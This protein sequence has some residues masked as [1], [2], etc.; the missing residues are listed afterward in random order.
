[1]NYKD[2]MEKCEK[3]IEEHLE[4]PPSATE[5]AEFSGY[6][7]YH[8][9]HLFRAHFGVPV[10]EYAPSKAKIAICGN[11]LAS[12]EQVAMMIG[13]TLKV[14]LD[15]KYLDATDA[16]AIE[17]CHYYQTS[18]PLASVKSKGGWKNF[19]ESNPERVKK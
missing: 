4:Y 8:F 11:G 18:N 16:V 6:S 3:Y 19:I 15:P 13:K 2:V 7:L 17:M 14:D 10:A 12:K 9:C 5:L 1:M